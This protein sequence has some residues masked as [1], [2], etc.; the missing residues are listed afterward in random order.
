MAKVRLALHPPAS[1]ADSSLRPVLQGLDQ[2]FLQTPDTGL[3]LPDVTL[4]LTLG[5]REAAR[6]GGYGEER[7]VRDFLTSSA[8]TRAKGPLTPYTSAHSIDRRYE[9]EAFQ[10]LVRAKFDV[11]GATL[12]ATH[13]TGSWV[14]VDASGSV[15]DVRDRIWE[16]VAG[17][18]GA[19]RQGNLWLS[20]DV[21]RPDELERHR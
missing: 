16:L 6:R 18:V 11:V 19:G 21:S 5:A 15:D 7:F 10:T 4:F 12:N 20:Q 3:P 9:L 2:R 14:E 13:G 17:R 1:A 8:W